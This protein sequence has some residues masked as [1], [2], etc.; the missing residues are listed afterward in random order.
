MIVT[1][2]VHVTV[3]SASIV[4]ASA[5]DRFKNASKAVAV[6]SIGALAASAAEVEVLATLIVVPEA[7]VVAGIIFCSVVAIV[8]LDCVAVPTPHLHDAA[9]FRVVAIAE[10]VVNPIVP[11]AP[12]NRILPSGKS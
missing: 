12:R 11:V 7:Q 10:V 3:A 4:V 1:V 8:V 5:T 2:P 9:L 6:P